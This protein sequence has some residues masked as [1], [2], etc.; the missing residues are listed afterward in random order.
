MTR[1]VHP[2]AREVHVTS[3]SGVRRNATAW[4][5]T[6]SY[7]QRIAVLRRGD[8]GLDTRDA[9]ALHAQLCAAQERWDAAFAW[10]QGDTLNRRHPGGLEEYMDGR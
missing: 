9:D 2:L 10:W 8:P 1:Y 3:S 5:G 6:D 7:D 4:V